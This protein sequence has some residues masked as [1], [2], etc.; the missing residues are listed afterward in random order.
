[1]EAPVIQTVSLMSQ[2]PFLITPDDDSGSHLLQS[3]V[4]KDLL[5]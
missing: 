4:D 1:M 2:V 3:K 5:A